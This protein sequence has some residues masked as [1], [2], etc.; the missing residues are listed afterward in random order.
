MSH[1]Q[2]YSCPYLSQWIR[3]QMHRL[4][5]NG[6]QCASVR[7]RF[8]HTHTYP[9]TSSLPPPSLSL[10]S[11]LPYS[12]SCS[13]AGS[14]WRVSTSVCCISLN[15]R[16]R[17]FALFQLLSLLSQTHLLH[18]CA[19]A[20]SR[21]FVF[22]LFLTGSNVC[23]CV[24]ACTSNRLSTVDHSLEPASQTHACSV[25]LFCVRVCALFRTHPICLYLR[26]SLEVH[27]DMS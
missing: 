24:R 4:C 23:V 5:R 26:L 25:V 10:S 9:Y 27:I 8:A 2:I 3:K 6:S 7:H 13:L 12:L 17:A 15:P 14:L 1:I 20:F 16:L 19:H 21:F 18:A 22:S 11:L